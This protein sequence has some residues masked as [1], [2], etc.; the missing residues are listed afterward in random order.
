METKENT[1]KQKNGVSQ[2]RKRR[3]AVGGHCRLTGRTNHNATER[4]LSS[5]ESY[6]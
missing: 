4:V 1:E 5:D 3:N 2:D 6:G